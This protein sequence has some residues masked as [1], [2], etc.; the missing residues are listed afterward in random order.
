MSKDWYYWDFE[1]L[2][3]ELQAFQEYNQKIEEQKQMDEW[4]EYNSNLLTNTLRIW[5]K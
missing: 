4:Q 5:N 3:D 2:A 1:N